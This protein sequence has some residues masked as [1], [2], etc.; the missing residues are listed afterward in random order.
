[1]TQ[2]VLVCKVNP[3]NDNKVCNNIE[4]ICACVCVLKHTEE[5]CASSTLHSNSH[6]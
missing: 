2:F 4:L 1:M 5:I 3:Y 6:K